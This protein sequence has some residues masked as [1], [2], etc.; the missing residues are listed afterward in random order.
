MTSTTPCRIG[1]HPVPE[2]WEIKSLRTSGAK[3]ITIASI[4]LEHS[5]D[6][7][8]KINIAGKVKPDDGFGPRQSKIEMGG[9][10]AVHDPCAAGRGLRNA[11]TK[12]PDLGLNPTGVP[13][14]R[15]EMH[16]RKVKACADVACKR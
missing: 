8:R 7:A 10:V 5:Q 13:K 12:P 3:I 11:L 9:V 6:R 14:Y 16:D 4:V 1:P 15:V 2:K